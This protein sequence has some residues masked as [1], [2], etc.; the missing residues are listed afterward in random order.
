[1]YILIGCEHS[2]FTGKVRAYLKWKGVSFQEAHVTS[3]AYRSV[4]LPQVGWSVIPVL[5]TPDGNVIQDTSD[6]IDHIEAIHPSPSVH[7]PGFKQK[8]V[9]YIFEVFADQW[10]VIPAMHYRWNFPENIP[11]LKYYWGKIVPPKGL[12][13][14]MKMFSGMITN[15]G[16]T[17]NTIPKI[18]ESFLYL[19][20]LLED[21]FKSH[22]YLLGSRPCLGDF[23][24]MGPFYAH[25]YRDPV[26]GNILK[27]RAPRVVE[28]IERCCSLTNFKEQKIIWS[29]TKPFVKVLAGESSFASDDSIP[30]T[31]IPILEI[32]F[33]QHVPVLESICEKFNKFSS[34]ADH[35]KE[36]PRIIG[37]G[38]FEY[39]GETAKR[40]QQP[41]DLWMTQRVLDVI[42]EAKLC[43]VDLQNFILGFSNGER[44]LKLEFPRMK[45]KIGK[46]SSGN[47]L[48]FDE[49]RARL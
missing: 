10:L 5:I 44:L 11:F 27:M 17:P 31:L 47:N 9:S 24:M 26:P 13:R 6:I 36:I 35:S 32:W 22:H 40:L 38:K 33:K 7:P 41:Y 19:L 28:W 18:E 16:I 49:M 1:M 48:F 21:H 14:S 45:R 42:K 15:L 25:L 4:I 23:G 43:G 30:P 12:D 3:E 34:K 29:R 39:E 37:F 8:L 2:L 20:D 46:K